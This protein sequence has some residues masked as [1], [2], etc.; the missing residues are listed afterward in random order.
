MQY[1]SWSLN[2]SGNWTTRYGENAFCIFMNVGKNNSKPL[3]DFNEGQTGWQR[4][5]KQLARVKKALISTDSL[6]CYW[7]IFKTWQP[8]IFH[9][10]RYC[11]NI[12][13]AL[14]LLDLCCF[15]SSSEMLS[16][17]FVLQYQL[18]YKP[19]ILSS[20][21]THWLLRQSRCWARAYCKL[22]RGKCYVKSL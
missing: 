2:F 4:V 19:H 17:L 11:V 12:Q 9:F 14:L 21:S 10:S 18:Y 20:L 22:W 1:L 16:L 3:K 13:G 6:S 7:K 5:R 15:I 8:P